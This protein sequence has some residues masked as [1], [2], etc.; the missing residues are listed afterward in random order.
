MPYKRDKRA[1]MLDAVTDPD[2]RLRLEDLRRYNPQEFR[3]ELRR[4]ARRGEIPDLEH[5][6]D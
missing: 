2:E 1:L 4:M 6:A 3:K 5:K